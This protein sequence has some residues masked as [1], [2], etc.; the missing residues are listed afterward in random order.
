MASRALG[1][2]LERVSDPVRGP[3]GRLSEETAVT[4]L[5]AALDGAWSLDI[6]LLERKYQRVDDELLDAALDELRRKVLA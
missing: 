2:D 6:Y 5:V 3:L 4:L 1:W